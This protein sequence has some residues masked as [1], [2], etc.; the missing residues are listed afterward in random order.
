MAV[1]GEAVVAVV[2]VVVVECTAR[3]RETG[4]GAAATKE[5]SLRVSA[6]LDTRGEAEPDPPPLLPL[7]PIAVAKG[8][9]RRAIRACTWF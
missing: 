1:L 6:G 5:C 2:V 9:S 4:G 8:T 3:L 7:A